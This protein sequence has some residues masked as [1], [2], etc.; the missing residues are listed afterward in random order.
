MANNQTD[1]FK[2]KIKKDRPAKGRR[3]PTAPQ[4]VVQSATK[5]QIIGG[6]MAS[7]DKPFQPQIG[8]VTGGGP[9]KTDTRETKTFIDPITGEKKTAFV[10]GTKLKEGETRIRDSQATPEPTRPTA[11]LAEQVPTTMAAGG[12]GGGGGLSAEQRQFNENVSKFLAAR[13]EDAAAQERRGARGIGVGEAVPEAGAPTPERGLFE[14]QAIIAKQGEIIATEQSN[15]LFS[16]KERQ[17]RNQLIASINS[18]SNGQALEAEKF[19]LGRLTTPQLEE[20]ASSEGIELSTKIKEQLQSKGKSEIENLKQWRNSRQIENDYMRKQL[21]R[22]FRRSLTDAEE[23][24]NQQD[25]KLRRLAAAFG[26][27]KVQSLSAN[28]AVMK[29]SAK[30]ASTLNDIRESFFDRETLLSREAQ[31][32]TD[33][34]SN[35]VNLIEDRMATALEDKLSEISN[36]VDSLIDAGITNREDLN[37]ATAKAKNEYMKLYFDISEKSLEFMAEQNQQLFDNQVKLQ[38][39]QVEAKQE[40]QVNRFQQLDSGPVE[41]T[42]GRTSNIPDTNNSPGNLKA[43]GIGDKFAA[44]DSE[45]NLILS[46]RGEGN[47]LTFDDPTDGF[48]A[49]MADIQAKQTGNTR[50][51]LNANSSLLDFAQV[52]A[53]SG[54]GYANTIAQI[55][56]VDINTPIGQIDIGVFAQGVAKA[57][58]FTGQISP[59]IGLEEPARRTIAGVGAEFVPT[60]ELDQLAAEVARGQVDSI[61]LGRRGFGEEEINT[62]QNRAREIRGLLPTVTNPEIE[63]FALGIIDDPKTSLRNI[64]TGQRGAVQLRLNEIRESLPGNATFQ[65]LGGKEFDK[66]T[67]LFEVQNRIDTLKELKKKVN[68]GFISAKAFA[69][70]EFTGL[71]GQKTEDFVSLDLVSGKILAD[72]IKEISG[73][74]VSEQEAQRLA[75]LVPNVGMTDLRFNK[76]LTQMEDELTEILNRNAKRLG[77]ETS[78]DLGT[79]V[80]TTRNVLSGNISPEDVAFPAQRDGIIPALPPGPTQQTFDFVGTTS[81][82]AIEFLTSQGFDNPTQ[83]EI[84][85]ILNQVQ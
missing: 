74:A 84:N 14:N 48:Q 75:K 64:P 11:T 3:V 40:E 66:I 53:N 77:F 67:D 6:T 71:G 5:S 58:G 43:G 41:V 47:F 20:L 28:V 30:G 73:A 42:S 68:T 2:E 19:E 59:T 35:N 46:Q 36:I 78:E 4:E 51:R 55:A 82:E 63:G 22:T 61:E 18:T 76:A 70:Q 54:Q 24:N 17:R 85:F 9:A 79:G 49:M 21:E 69:A 1:P 10:A 13:E 80:D 50:T 83:D 12:R 65:D 52:Y 15:N 25:A 16:Q 29:E 37:T 72:F 23:F 31:Q 60:G 39:L 33:I 7:I 32:V 45:G 62:I 38:E 44:R 27:G 8:G 81:D 57:E 26:G 56:G 34:Y